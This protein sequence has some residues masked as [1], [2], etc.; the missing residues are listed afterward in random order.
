MSEDE[1]E[2]KSGA[3]DDSLRQSEDCPNRQ[4][5]VYTATEDTLFTKTTPALSGTHSLVSTSQ[6]YIPSKCEN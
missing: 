3:A 6:Y 4:S 2:R 1:Q 5:Q